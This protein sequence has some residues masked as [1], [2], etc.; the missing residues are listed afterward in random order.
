[1]HLHL[2][3]RWALLNLPL[4][5]VRQRHQRPSSWLKPKTVAVAVP[6]RAIQAVRE[7]GVPPL[8][9]EVVARALRRRA[10]AVDAQRHR[11]VAAVVL[12]RHLAAAVVRSNHVE[13]SVKGA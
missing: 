11:A 13:V 12:Q 4:G 6:Q 3:R 8:Q 9:A 10:A 5:W 7:V 1:M 2:L